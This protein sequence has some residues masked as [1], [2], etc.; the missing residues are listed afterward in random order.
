M[1]SKRALE[2]SLVSAIANFHSKSKFSHDFVCTS[3]HHIMYRKSVVPCNR[4]KYTKASVEI[5]EKVFA[6]E[7]EYVC[8]DGRQWVC[9]TCDG[10]L[11]RG[12]IRV[13]AKANG[14]HLQPIPPELSC[15]NA[16]E[17]RLVSLCVPF[18]NIVALPTGKQH[19]IHG[20]AVD[21]PSRLDSICTMLP[22]LPSQSELVPLKFKRKLSYNGHYMYDYITP[23][24]MMNALM[25]LKANN[26][27]YADVVIN[28]DWTDQSLYNDADLRT[29]LL[30]QPDLCTSLL[31]QPDVVDEHMDTVSSTKQ[32]HKQADTGSTDDV[33]T[34]FD[35][36]KAAAAEIG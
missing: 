8:S 36:L 10:A 9:T 31:Q 11:K 5:L 15:L 13:Q 34:A 32:P 12:N 24:N 26:P 6:N 16:M 35:T 25:W 7:F 23:E 17:L 22:R 33:T 27:L 4:N 1:A 14:S 19:S 2:M 18:M 30:Q 3:C 21:V 20:P 29:S 28:D